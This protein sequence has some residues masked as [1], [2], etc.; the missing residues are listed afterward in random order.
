MCR[1]FVI[2]LLNRRALNPSCRLFN[3]VCDKKFFNG[4]KFCIY[5]YWC[6][7]PLNLAY[8][9]LKP[10]AIVLFFSNFNDKRLI[11]TYSRLLN[12]LSPISHCYLIIFLKLRIS[13]CILCRSWERKGRIWRV[14][15]SAGPG[16][17]LDKKLARFSN[18]ARGVTMSSLLRIL[19]RY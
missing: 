7:H 4:L 8:S 18:P 13:T 3:F 10:R 14:F 12:R 6:A 2:V 17:L 16:A 19:F 5:F 15:Q 11:I 9:G 1:I